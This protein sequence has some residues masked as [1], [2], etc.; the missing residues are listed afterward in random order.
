[1]RRT[2]FVLLAFVA[3]LL[4]ACCRLVLRTRKPAR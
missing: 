2:R 4:A 1:M 3:V